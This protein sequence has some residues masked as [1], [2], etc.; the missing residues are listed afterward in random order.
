MTQRMWLFSLLMALPFAF[1]ACGDEATEDVPVALDGIMVS[2]C[3]LGTDGCDR[4]LTV[5][6]ED[7]AV[8]VAVLLD[9]APS[10][11]LV[12]ADTITNPSGEV[13]ADFWDDAPD[14]LRVDANDGLYITF[15]P[16]NP[17]VNL[18][19]GDWKI[20]YYTDASAPWKGSPLLVTKSSPATTKK[21]DLNLFFVD[22]P[23]L[24]ADD[25]KNNADFQKI[26]A[27]VETV[28]D[29]AGISFGEISYEDVTGDD[30]D[31]YGVV[32]LNNGELPGLFKLSAGKSNNAMNLFFVADLTDG[33]DFVQLGQA[34]GVP[35]PPGIHGTTRSGLV[36]N[37]A[38]FVAAADDADLLAAASNDASLIIA[39]EGCHYL[40]LFHTT[41]KNGA[42]LKEGTNGYDP[43][44]DTPECPDSA[45]TSGN[46]LLGAKECGESGGG[47][48]LMFWSPPNELSDNP[49]T[50]PTRTLTAGQIAILV[51]NPLIQ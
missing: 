48:N 39:H 15:I 14:Q 17:D 33:S 1:A 49:P 13:L 40:G 22:V 9:G 29:Q 3:D 32:D 7:G 5:P 45:D 38:S 26:L 43:I 35:G 12:L 42:A 23:G 27:D 2:D 51:K 28:L 25:A 21:M 8:S 37:L 6:V 4:T 31:K 10:G 47:G 41:E 18:D 11:A 36:V 19:A 44:A 30:A 16:N 46:G 34:G 24:S 50:F 20:S